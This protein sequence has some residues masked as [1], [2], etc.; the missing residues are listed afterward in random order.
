GAEFA[1]L[2]RLELSAEREFLALDS[3]HGSV[4]LLPLLR[5]ELV[6]DRVR[7]SG[8]KARIVKGKDGRF[9]FQDL[10]E[11]E[12]QK[13][14]AK[15]PPKDPKQGGAVKFDIAGL[16]VERSS[17]AYTDLNSGQE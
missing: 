1:G 8:L 9:N 16:S 11:P 7:V 14:A 2:S 13:P 3:A 5:G 17:L 10:I 4:A 12:G 6:V 15:A